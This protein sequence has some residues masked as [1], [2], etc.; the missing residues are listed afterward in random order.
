MSDLRER[1]AKAIH[2]YRRGNHPKLY[3]DWATEVDRDR[4]HDDLAYVSSLMDESQAAIQ[5]FAEAMLSDA[6]VEVAADEIGSGWE[7]DKPEAMEDMRRALTAALAAITG[8][9]GGKG[10]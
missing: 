2:G 8:T 9:E 3:D 4:R 6:A 1:V 10:E 7:K 5:A